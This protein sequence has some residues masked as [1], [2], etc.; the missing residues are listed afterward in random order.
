LPKDWG[1]LTGVRPIKLL[2]YLANQGCNNANIKEYLVN[3]Q[4][5]NI[6]TADLMIDLFSLEVNTLGNIKKESV[7]L[8]IHIPFCPSRCTYCSFVSMSNFHTSNLLETYAELLIIE[9]NHIVEYVKKN[10]LD[11]VSIYFGGGTPTILE[12]TY[13]EKILR[14]VKPLVSEGL[15]YTIEAGRPNTISRTKLEVMEHYGVNRICVNPQSMIDSTLKKVNRQHTATDI[16][17]TISLASNFN[18]KINMDM[19]VGLPEEEDEDILYSLREILALNPDEITVHSLAIKRASEINELAKNI[20]NDLYDNIELLLM[21]NNYKP[22]YL[23]KQSNSLNDQANIGYTKDKPCL[24]NMIMINEQF[25]VISCGAGAITKLLDKNK[26]FTRFNAP[27]DVK[28][29]IDNF[30]EYLERKKRWFDDAK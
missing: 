20:T 22:Y 3:E 15:E 5:L 29:Y 19:I 26:Q 18:M 11:I 12:V 30:D 13:L 10:N 27:K 21:K 24:Y 14:E 7:A 23:Y 16:K 1:N 9:I 6:E 2:Y 8:Y 17:S 28:M 25:S 4:K